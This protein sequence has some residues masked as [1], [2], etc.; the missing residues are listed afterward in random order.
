MRFCITTALALTL[1]L[2]ACGDDNDTHFHDDAID[3]AGGEDVTP[4][5]DDAG[6]ETDTPPAC[7]GTPGDEVLLHESAM[8]I[9]VVAAPAGTAA[10]AAICTYTPAYDWAVKL[11][12]S[13]PCRVLD[14]LFPIAEPPGV[15][16]DTGDITITINGGTEYQL[17]DA[18]TSLACFRGAG[19]VLPALNTG[20]TIRAW[21]TGGSDVPAFDLSVTVPE[22]PAVSA[23]AEGATLTTCLPWTVAWSPAAAGTVSASIVTTV[24]DDRQ[25][26]IACRELPTSPLVIPP[27]L[28]GLW[29]TESGSA[30]LNFG[31]S[32][33]TASATTPSVTLEV[34]RQGQGLETLVIARP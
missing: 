34:Q 12:E 32:A 31:I 7:P 16:L 20:D 29:T 5:E 17:A 11:A 21:S 9:V 33:Q 3:D 1:A 18:A 28:T 19:E 4:P 27:E 10:S 13:G 22:L 26:T 24:A 2:G 30:R 23:P 14:W 15:N 6:E 25:F 8:R